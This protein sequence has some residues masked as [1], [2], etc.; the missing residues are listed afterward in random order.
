MLNAIGGLVFLVVTAWMKG[1]ELH[2]KQIRKTAQRPTGRG[3][4]AAG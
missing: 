1:C 4:L 2:G 3:R